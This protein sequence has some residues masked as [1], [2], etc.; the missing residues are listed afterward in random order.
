MPVVSIPTVSSGS[1]SG[2]VYQTDDFVQPTLA[3][4][5]TGHTIEL[6]DALGVVLDTVV[7]TNGTGAYSFTDLP[8]ATYF[9]SFLMVLSADRH[10]VAPTALTPGAHAD[11]TWDNG[12]DPPETLYWHTVTVLGE[13]TG[14][15]F[16]VWIRVD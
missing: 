14:I 1:I 11:G 15:D 10:L 6:R 7:C 2:T 9:V 13:M 4:S 16:A 12:S 3:P 8:A 5:P